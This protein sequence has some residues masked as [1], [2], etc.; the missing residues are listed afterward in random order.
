MPRRDCHSPHG[1]DNK[2]NREITSLV[3]GGI[4]CG[5]VEAGDTHSGYG[6]DDSMEHVSNPSLDAFPPFTN[7]G[8][9]LSSGKCFGV[10]LR[11][12]PSGWVVGVLSHPDTNHGEAD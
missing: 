7:C 5:S 6:A 2:P 3:N 10:S 9:H 12:G 8:G 11:S 4:G 1:S